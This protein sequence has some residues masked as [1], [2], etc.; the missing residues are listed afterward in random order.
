MFHFT[1]GTK[2]NPVGPTTEFAPATRWRSELGVHNAQDGKDKIKPGVKRAT[3]ANPVG[4]KGP[5]QVDTITL[6]V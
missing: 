6:C 1:K 3:M 5:V 4:H 2:G